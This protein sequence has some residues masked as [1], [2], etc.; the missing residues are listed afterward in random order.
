[1]DYKD[2]IIAVLTGGVGAAVVKFVFD[3]VAWRR[4]RKAEKED[5]QESN[6]EE[7]LK[8]IEAQNKAQSEAIKFILYDRIRYLGQ[9]YVS[10]KEINI[11]DRRILNEMHCSY[12]QGLGGNGDLDVLMKQVNNLPLK[13]NK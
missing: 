4:N 12:H 7:R 8:K 1:M 3:A 5:R 2:I 11:D 6:A 13:L 9:Y 10:E